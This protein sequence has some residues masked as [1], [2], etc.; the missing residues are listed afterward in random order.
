MAHSQQRIKSLSIDGLRRLKRLNIS[1]EDKNVTGIF[2][3][4]GSGKTTL[5]YTLLCLY[6]PINGTQYNFGSFF[7]RCKEHEFDNT[8]IKASVHYR[9]VRDEKDI[10]VEYKKSLG[11]DRWTPKTS[12][13]PER[14]VFY[15]GINTCVPLI[16]EEIKITQK[17]NYENGREISDSVKQAASNILGIPYASISHKKRGKKEHYHATIAD[18]SEYY[19][20]SMGAGEQRILRILEF[21]ENIP[22]YSLIIIDEIDLTLH[23]AAL[24]RLMDYLVNIASTCHHQIVFTSHREELIKRKDINI[25]HI[26]QT[27]LDTLCFNE[28]KPDCMDRLTGSTIR[29]LEI[30]VEDDLAETIIAKCAQD[31]G[32]RKR[33]DIKHFGSCANAFVL[34]SALHMM[35]NDLS[36][37]LFV[38]DGDLYKTNQDRLSQIKKHYTGDEPGKEESR[39]AVL[40]SIKSLNLP[41]GYSP[42][43]YINNIIGKAIPTSN[44]EL[45]NAANEIIAPPDTHDYL[46]KIIEKTGDSRAIGLF[47]IIDE[48][49]KH[50]EWMNYTQQV[51]DWLD[52]KRGELVL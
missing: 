21:L 39:N 49:S 50:P 9:N 43:K 38:L 20:V 19:S 4:N 24:N 16:E 14:D 18:G 36:N 8:I 28:T 51:T 29:P 32:I 48:M 26:F 52:Q 31:L 45:R 33:V 7:K 17:Y 42:E 15:F 30:Y 47:K 10:I 23:T 3:A 1:F 11:S 27:P 12:S 40:G 34:S 44:E 5:L 41:D 13:R 22:D 35:G 46:D 25:R 2:G 6:K 37:Q